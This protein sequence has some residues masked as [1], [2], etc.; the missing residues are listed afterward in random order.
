MLCSRVAIIKKGKIAATGTPSELR[1]TFQRVQSVEV[2]FSGPVSP[3]EF[4]SLQGVGELK[5]EGER[6][7]L[8]TDDPTFVASELVEFARRTGLKI[9]SLAIRGP[10]LEDVFV[11]ITEGMT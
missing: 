6:L 2:E 10:T 1:S 4:S 3:K 7:R 5:V 8:M 9:V 11:E